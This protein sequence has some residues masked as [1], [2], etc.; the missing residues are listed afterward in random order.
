MRLTKSSTA[1]FRLNQ[2]ASLTVLSLLCEK[3]CIVNSMGTIATSL[4]L[5]EWGRGEVVLRENMLV[6]FFRCVRLNEHACK[7]HALALK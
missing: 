4:D 2:I 6:G 3:V 5:I 1:L 7:S